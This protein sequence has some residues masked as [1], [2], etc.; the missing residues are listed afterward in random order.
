[1]LLFE[2]AHESISSTPKTSHGFTGSEF[3]TL[4]DSITELLNNDKLYEDKKVN[5]EKIL[6]KMIDTM[7]NLQNQVRSKN[8]TNEFGLFIEAVMKNPLK[9]LAR[10][11]I[12][13]IKQAK[14]ENYFTKDPLAPIT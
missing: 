13:H 14:G 8:F 3:G 2:R 6:Q 7:L 12:K 5:F 1:M 9:K 11:I 10:K 4:C